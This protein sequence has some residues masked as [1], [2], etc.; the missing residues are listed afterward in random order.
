M[1]T[2]MNCRH[3]ELKH[4]PPFVGA[5]HRYPP[6]QTRGHIPLAGQEEHWGFPKIELPSYCS[7]WRKL[8]GGD[9]P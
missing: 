3:F 2:C 7:E 1:N 5:C 9:F 8:T 6:E 4:Q